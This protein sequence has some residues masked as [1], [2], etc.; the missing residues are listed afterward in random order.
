MLLHYQKSKDSNKSF[1]A[2]PN[3]KGIQNAPIDNL[4]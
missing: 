1:T 4:I 3:K 2:I